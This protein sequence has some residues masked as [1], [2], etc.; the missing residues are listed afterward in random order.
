M[1][2]IDM[3]IHSVSRLLLTGLKVNHGESSVWSPPGPGNFPETQ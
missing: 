1:Q 3:P 2:C